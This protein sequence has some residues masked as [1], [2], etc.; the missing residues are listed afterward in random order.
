MADGI[1]GVAINSRGGGGGRKQ[2]VG[3]NRKE[4]TWREKEKVKRLSKRKP[5]RK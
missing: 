2:E 3:Q 4:K 1:K 5:E